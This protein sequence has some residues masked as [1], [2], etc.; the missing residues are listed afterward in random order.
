MTDIL[1]CNSYYLAHDPIARRYP[2]FYPPLGTLY[3]AAY[4]RQAGLWQVDVFDAT[5][6]SGEDEFKR[7]V[8]HTRPRIIGIQALITT[9]KSAQRM[10]QIAKDSG[11]TVIMGGPDPTVCYEE[12]LRWGADFVVLGE[13]ELTAHELILYLTE[14]TN[15]NLRDIFGLAY[16]EKEGLVVTPPRKLISNLDELPLPAL[17]MIDVSRYFEIWKQGHGHTSLHFITSRGC[18]FTCT[19]CSR[20]VFGR[21]FRQRSVANVVDEMQFLIDQYNPDMLWI[22]DDTFGLNREWLEIWCE[23][24][25]R[26]GI[27]IPFRCFTRVDQVN[28]RMLNKL[29]QVGC[30]RIH[31]GVESGSQRILNSMRKKSCVEDNRRVSQQIQEAGINLNY[32]IMFGYPG[33]TFED[34]KLTEQLILETRPNSVGYSIAYPVPG[35]EFYEQ[36]RDRLIIKDQDDLWAKT[37]QGIQL[38]FRAQYPLIYYRIVIHYIESRLKSLNIK[39]PL[40]YRL[41]NIVLASILKNMKWIFESIWPLLHKHNL[42]HKGMES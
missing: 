36:V 22:A 19:W 31:I 4:L 10:I 1:I 34:I 12:Y 6:A 38:L 20:A 3:I 41:F 21:T 35:T 39:E 25:M 18:P 7:T 14:R 32:F 28:P 33:E 17:D 16:W 40:K 29:K 9:R 24:V 37:T 26:R 27:Y 2:S 11:A 13:G 30:E 8:S 42:I 15:M 23:E 5:L